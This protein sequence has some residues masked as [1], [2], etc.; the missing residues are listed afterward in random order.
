MSRFTVMLLIVPASPL[1]VLESLQPERLPWGISPLLAKPLL[2]VLSYNSG[3]RCHRTAHHQGQNKLWSFHGDC[4]LLCCGAIVAVA[5]IGGVCI[6]V[7]EH[8]VG[9][10]GI[11][12][13]GCPDDGRT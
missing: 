1:S 7:I 12:A 5:E 9:V 11:G 2:K 10:R 8:T 13:Q 6:G 4:H 3:L